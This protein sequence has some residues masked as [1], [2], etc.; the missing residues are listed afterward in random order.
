M[1]K[2]FFIFNSILIIFITTT[3]YAINRSEGIP[4]ID[5]LP[6]VIDTKIEDKKINT[7]TPQQ[8]IES[9]SKEYP[10]FPRIRNLKVIE[11][12]TYPYSA[13]IMWEVH[14][15]QLRLFTLLDIVNQF[16]LKKF[17]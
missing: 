8:N 13:K 10:D 6:M 14:P 9:I 7:T 17:Y 15:Q 12:T 4:G 2:Y 11:D 3:I 1:K 5:P 16:P